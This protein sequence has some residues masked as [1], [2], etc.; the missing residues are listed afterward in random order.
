MNGLAFSTFVG[1]RLN[2]PDPLQGG[3]LPS[4]TD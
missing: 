1:G 2:D 4:L 3:H